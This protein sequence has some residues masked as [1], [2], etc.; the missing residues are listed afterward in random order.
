MSAEVAQP[1]LDQNEVDAILN[2]MNVGRVSTS[3]APEPS[4]VRPY[5]LGNEARIVRGRMPTLEIMNE[6]FVRLYRDS[7][8]RLLRRPA[9]IEVA[10]IQTLKFGD[11]VHRL[12]VPTSLH[13]VRMPP[14]RGSVL[15]VVTPP[16]VFGWVDC[17]FGGRGRPSKI[18]GRDFTAT[19]QRIIR[20]FL[21]AAFADLQTAWE[22]VLPVRIEH[23][24]SESNPQFA[25][26]IPSSE[27][28]VVIAFRIEIDG[29]VGE[30]HFTIP[31]AALE[32]WRAHLDS[33]DQ[34]THSSM[35]GR[36][37][38]S[39]R[40]DL[41]DADVGITT[42]LGTASLTLAELVNLAP[43][44]VVPCDFNGKVTV[45]AE[46]VPVLRGSFG[47]SRGQQAVKV[48]QRIPGL[49]TATGAAGNGARGERTP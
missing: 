18:E 38:R 49:G 4:N 39:L 13:I 10:A 35:D 5:D 11:Y 43:G 3:P 40:E 37:A 6:R 32:P 36:W 41:G 19:E 21:D 7:V 31:Y 23:L 15:V 17:F 34:P 45:Y 44:D 9:T 12:H 47:V 42:R 46:D 30:L 28:I 26:I 2:G 24:A 1:V 14:L 22:Q 20:M 33:G 29:G 27:T 25:N 16:L 8:Y 48:E